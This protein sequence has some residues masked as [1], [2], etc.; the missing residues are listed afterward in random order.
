MY[1]E[2]RLTLIRHLG[3]S[4]AQAQRTFNATYDR[5]CLRFAGDQYRY[6]WILG[7]RSGVFSENTIPELALR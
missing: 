5:D 7:D 1:K 3:K 6:R 4:P 2:D